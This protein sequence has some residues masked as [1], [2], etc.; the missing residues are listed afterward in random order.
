M[1]RPG[2]S[3]PAVPE[4]T[5]CPRPL[6]RGRGASHANAVNDTD[7]TSPFA[8]DGRA[9]S[10]LARYFGPLNLAAYVTWAAVMLDVVQSSEPLFD[11]RLGNALPVLVALAFIALF[12]SC[13]RAGPRSR[14][15]IPGLVA[16]LLAALALPSTSSAD[17]A[18]ILL[19]V[20]MAHAGIAL[21]KQGLLFATIAV[22]NLALYVILAEV[23][24][25]RKPLLITALYAGFQ[26]FAILTAGYAARAEAA[27]SALREVNAHLLATRSLLE[28]SARDA[29]RLRLAREL[30]DVA[31]HTLTAL[32]L[33]LLALSRDRALAQ[34]TELA[35][36]VALA[37][38]L[39]GDIRGVVRQMRLHEGVELADALRQIAA[40]FPKPR[41]ELDI[42]PG[43]RVADVNQAEALVRAAQEALTN[44]AR[45]ADAAHVTLKLARVADGV[46]L[47]VIDDG[48]GARALAPGHGLRGMRER[49]E[50]V[51]GRV[52]FGNTARGFAVRAF[53]PAGAVA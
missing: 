42:E 16:L 31:G 47:E 27:S 8:R 23:W 32:K 30:H 41:I 4:V 40:P 10:G 6:E 24:E 44:A 34:R 5:T 29:E 38:Q 17:S 2:A 43:L 12:V 39:L 9:P 19:V 21:R 52:E 33:N 20:A 45:H 46:A 1:A 22:V 48:R 36:A 50:A 18:P 35:T 49:L 13:D 15:E 25:A 51:G 26:T 7:Q 11:T 3:R 37:D 14:L 28:A 53:L